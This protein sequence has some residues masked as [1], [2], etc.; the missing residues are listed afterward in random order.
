MSVVTARN[1]DLKLTAT[2][3]KVFVEICKSR[4]SRKKKYIYINILIT[5]VWTLLQ[6]IKTPAPKY[7][8][9]MEK[10]FLTL[11]DLAPWQ[12]HL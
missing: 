3:D 8:I 11:G 4:Y 9:K 7:C 12:R 6:K 5:W 1:T 10:L 2:F